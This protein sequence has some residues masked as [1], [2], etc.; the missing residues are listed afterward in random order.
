MAKVTPSVVTVF[1]RLRAD[2]EENTLQ[3]TEKAN[4]KTEEAKPLVYFSENIPHWFTGKKGSDK[5]EYE[6]GSQ[7]SELTSQ[8]QSPS[9]GG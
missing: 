2:L 6:I 8:L 4:I 7:S 3:E 5:N 1:P 9:K